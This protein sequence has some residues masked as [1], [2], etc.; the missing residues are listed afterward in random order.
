[1][2]PCRLVTIV[3]T[4]QGPLIG[5]LALQGAFEEHEQC[6]Q[7]IGCRTRQV[8][9]FAYENIYLNYFGTATLFN[10]LTKNILFSLS[11]KKNQ[12]YTRR[13]GTDN[14]RFG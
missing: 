1:L 14:T 4:M 7:A 9:F 11:L 8:I 13:T 5:V 10:H 6:L 2:L 12:T 3:S